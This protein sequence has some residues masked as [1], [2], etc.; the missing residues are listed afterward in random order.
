VLSVDWLSAAS[1]RA[2]VPYQAQAGFNAA[3]Q[4]G[5]LAGL[6][7]PDEPLKQHIHLVSR[8][9]G[10]DHK[11]DQFETLPPLARRCEHDRPG[12]IRISRAL[13]TPPQEEVST[14]VMPAMDSVG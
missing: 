13:R 1:P 3:D 14:C 9:I 10:T 2:E 11:V 12:E 7:G 6:E 8:I 4:L 5:L